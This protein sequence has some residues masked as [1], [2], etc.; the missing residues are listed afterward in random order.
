MKASIVDLRYNMRD[1]IKALDRNEDVTILYRGRP[2][3]VIKPHDSNSEKKVAKH[4]FFNMNPGGNSVEEQM[5][6]LRGGRHRDL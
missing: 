1:V 5:E 3:G 4:P 6:L 2:K